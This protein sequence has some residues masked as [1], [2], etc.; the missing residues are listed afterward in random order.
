MME[1]VSTPA[2]K[3]EIVS[4]LTDR[5]IRFEAENMRSVTWVAIEEICSLEWSI[6]GPATTTDAVHALAPA[7]N[8]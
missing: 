8:E 7:K 6:G 4:E 3:K 5:V 1:R 2:R